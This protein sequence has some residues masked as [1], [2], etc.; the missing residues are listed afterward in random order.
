VAALRAEVERLKSSSGPAHDLNLKSK[1]TLGYWDIRGLGNQ[2][3][4]LLMFCGVDFVDQHYHM[5]PAPEFSRAD[6][7]DKKFTLGLDYPN[8]PYLIDEGINL[9]ET[10]AIMKYICAKWNPEL[11]GRTP[12]EIGNVEMMTAHC[13]ELKSKSTYPCYATDDRKAV[14]AGM[15]EP[16]KKVMDWLKGK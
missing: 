8:L 14:L 15:Q 16:L 13:V 7:L 4:A 9:T 10:N 2:C 11:L 1:P 5:G 3:R 6:W 12:V